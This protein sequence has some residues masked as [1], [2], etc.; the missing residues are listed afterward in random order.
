MPI[1]L[2]FGY[3]W[4]LLGR[5][6]LLLQ[7]LFQCNCPA[8]SEEARYPK[9]VGVIVSAC[10]DFKFHVNISPSGRL[11]YIQEKNSGVTSY[12]L[13]D[14]QTMRRVDI[15]DQPLSSFLTDD[16]WYLD[17]H[18]EKYIIDRITGV[19]FPI[20]KFVYSRP[21]GQINRKA[22]QPFLLESLRQSQ[23]IFL[24]GPST[25]TVVA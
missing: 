10:S 25:D 3:C 1:L 11:L 4:G 23:Q 6:S 12:Y 15:N 20:E 17:S 8:T 5:H 22:N 19:K 13:L 21:N 7:Y 16:L 9:N 2:Y 24:I 14:L 18:G